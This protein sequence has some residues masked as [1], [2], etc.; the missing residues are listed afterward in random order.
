MYYFILLSNGFPI[1]EIARLTDRTYH[2]VFSGI[3]R[4]KSLLELRDPAI[5]RLF[6]LTNNIKR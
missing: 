2:T 3:K 1:T 6:N 5:M 4:I